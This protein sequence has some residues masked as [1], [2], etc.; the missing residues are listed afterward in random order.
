[1]GRSFFLGALA[2]FKTATFLAVGMVAIGLGVGAYAFFKDHDTRNKGAVAE[3]KDAEKPKLIPKAIPY[4]L[5]FTPQK[6]TN[7]TPLP[8]IQAYVAVE[9]GGKLLVIGG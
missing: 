8:G 2:M 9:S 7:K 6:Y 4:T 3:K 1:M 5:K